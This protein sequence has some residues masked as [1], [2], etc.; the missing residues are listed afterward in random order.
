MW[1]SYADSIRKI[2]KQDE[3]KKGLKVKQERA[4][5][6]STRSPKKPEPDLKPP[7]FLTVTM[8]TQEEME[9]RENEGKIFQNNNTDSSNWVQVKIAKTA[10]IV[11]SNG[12]QFDIESITYVEP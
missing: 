11:D 5:I 9:A 12:K 2:A 3:T 7:L 10:R 1:K 8:E 4:A 6:G